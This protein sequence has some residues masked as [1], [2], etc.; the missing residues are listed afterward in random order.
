VRVKPE[1]FQRMMRTEAD[2]SDVVLRSFIMRRLG[3]I[4]HTEGATVLVGNMHSGDTLRLQSFLTRSGHPHKLL[5]TGSDPQAASALEKFRLGPEALP[6][7]ILQ[8]RKVL[9]TPTNRQ[10]ADALGIAENIDPARV[11]D[12]AVVGAGPA[13]LAAAVYAASEGLDTIVIE[14]N[15]PGGQ[16]GC[17][18]RIENYLGFP[19]G[20][21]G[22]DLSARAQVQAHKFGARLTVARAATRL[23]CGDN[24]F[25]IQLEDGELVSA[26]TVVVATGA[27]YRRLDVPGFTPFEAQGVHYAA[28]SIE[29]R[30][31]CG[32]DVAVVGGGNSAGQA[33]VYLSSLARHVHMLVRDDSLARTMSDYL[34][35]RIQESPRITLHTATEVSCLHGDK[36]LEAIGWREDGGPETVHPISNLFLMIGALPNTDWLN[37]CVDL[38]RAGFILTGHCSDS[39]LEVSPYAT[40]IP[41]V[42]AVGDVRSGSVKRVA[43]GVGEGSVVVHSVHRWLASLAQAPERPVS[44]PPPDKPVEP[45]MAAQLA[46][47]ARAGPGAGRPAV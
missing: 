38:D 7:V 5:D 29:G 31:C 3:L 18:S 4:R 39:W 19:M 46:G 43:S 11:H 36:S 44:R 6:A 9:Q 35:R 45:D 37:G 47:R 2:I 17:S 14:A 27:R 24:V 28:T 34:V 32:A 12:V 10:L 26:R 30:L 15:V 40:S 20:I 22:L 41:A 16:A 1:D 25:Q 42:F 21:S 13:G 8:G 33:A 23:L